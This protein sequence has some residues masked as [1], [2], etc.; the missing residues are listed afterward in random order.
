MLSGLYVKYHQTQFQNTPLSTA[1]PIAGADQGPSFQTHQKAESLTRL[2]WR[3]SGCAPLI[4]LSSRT[5]LSGI[6][7]LQSPLKW[8]RVAQDHG[9]AG[10]TAMDF[11][12]VCAGDVPGEYVWPLC[13]QSKN[14]THKMQHVH[15]VKDTVTHLVIYGDMG[16]NNSVYVYHVSKMYLVQ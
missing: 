11:S 10:A 7:P 6:S 14:T 2:V 3:R 8:T 16:I 9:Y 15:H 1:G 12:M 4:P 5:S 13:S